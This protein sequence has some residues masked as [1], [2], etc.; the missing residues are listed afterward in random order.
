M[1][2]KRAFLRI[3]LLAGAVVIVPSV[4]ADDEKKPEKAPPKRVEGFRAQPSERIQQLA[5][6]LNLTDEQKEKVRPIFREEAQQLRELRQ[7]TDLSRQDRLAK[8][9]ENRQELIGKL[10]EILTPEQLE[11]FKQLRSEG[12]RRRKQ[13]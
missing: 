6:E 5:K 7:N 10:K 2:L 13:E 9:K 12:P 3:L 11:K 1:K 8:L 4:P